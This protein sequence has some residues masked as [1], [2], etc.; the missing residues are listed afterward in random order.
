M[1]AL[2]LTLTLALA[3]CQVS[4]SKHQVYTV[5]ADTFA[6]IT[7]DVILSYKVTCNIFTGDSELTDNKGQLTLMY[8]VLNS[9]ED[10]A[11]LEDTLLAHA[12]YKCGDSYSTF[13][14]E[15]LKMINTEQHA[16]ITAA[17]NEHG[18]KEATTLLMRHANLTRAKAS[19]IIDQIYG[20][21]V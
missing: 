17:F 20:K 1:K 11:W 12:S 6:A 19:K 8:Q 10:R 18:R 7:G 13:F 9:Q 4:E 5:K 2:A 16:E 3:G 15:V 14:D 21:K